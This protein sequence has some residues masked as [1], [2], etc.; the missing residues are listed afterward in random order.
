MNNIPKKLR[1][2]MATDPFYAIC[3]VTGARATRQ[4]PIEWHHNLI[5]AGSQVQEKFAILPLKHSLHERINGDKQLK[6]HLDWIMLSRASE[7]QLERFSKVVDQRFNLAM[8]EAVYGHYA[9]QE[10]ELAIKY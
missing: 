7:E 9:P 3:C 1:E 10:Q 5:F 2:D 8:L 4:D 6:A